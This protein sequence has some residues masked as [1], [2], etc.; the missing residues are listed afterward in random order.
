MVNA[1]AQDQTITAKDAANNTSTKVVKVTVIA[2]PAGE[3][4]T[5]ST[6]K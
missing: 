1:T 2:A 6:K 3:Q 4:K 5:R